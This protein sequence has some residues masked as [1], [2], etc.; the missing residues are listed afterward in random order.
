MSALPYAELGCRSSF[1]FLEATALPEDLAARAAELGIGVVA[2][3]DYGGVYGAPRF[4]QAAK[5]AGIRAVVGAGLDVAGVGRVRLLCETRQGYQNLCRL[6]TLGHQKTEKGK[7]VVDADELRRFTDGLIC[8]VG[9]DPSIGDTRLNVLSKIYST[10]HIFIEITRH[11]DRRRDLVTERLLDLADATGLRPLAT[12]DVRLLRPDDKPLHDVLTCIHEHAT[13]ETAGRRLL[14]NGEARLK[15]PAE[16]AALFRDRPDAVRTAL[17]VAERCA[18][19][20]A[21]LGYR[22]PDY[23]VPPG[24]TQASYLRALTWAGAEVRYRPL[25]DAARAQITRE[26]ALIEKLDLAGYFLIV[27]DIVC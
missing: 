26:L 4:H 9:A 2:L 25:H 23:P 3:S 16:M 20:L 22:F 21:D 8:L 24:E 5:K 11:L 15:S 12:N 7:C 10:E 19:G 18:F 13:L 27:W 6:L 14:P 17:E 1:S